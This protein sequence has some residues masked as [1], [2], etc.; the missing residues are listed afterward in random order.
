MS[1]GKALERRQQ[2]K[3][4]ERDK[5]VFLDGLCQGMTMKK[6]A[7]LAAHP[8]DS[9]YKVRERDPEF[10]ELVIRARD[11]GTDVLEEEAFRRGTEGFKKPVI[12]K[13]AP[14]ID[15]HLKDENGEYIYE[16][17]YSDRLLEILL[18]GRRPEYR[19]KPTIDI[20]NQTLNVSLEDRSA[21]LD[22][23]ARVLESAGVTLEAAEGDTNGSGAS[24]QEL[25]ES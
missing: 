3:V 16:M 19:D 25:P 18:K 1:D 11:I 21:A 13:V 14:G 9:F 10:N 5:E 2:K 20:T 23:V 8:Y 7:E 6:A 4:T 24:Y 12:G 15:G 17:V 22:A